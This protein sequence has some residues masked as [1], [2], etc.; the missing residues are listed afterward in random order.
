M[1]GSPSDPADV[2]IIGSG[3]AGAVLGAA[4]VRQGVRV[5]VLES[6]PRHAFALRARAQRDYLRGVDPWARQPATLDL[7][8]NAGALEYPLN[9]MRVRGVGGT[10]LHWQAETPRM[11]ASDFRMHSLYG[12]GADWPLPYEELEPYYV[13]AEHE[14]GVAGGEDPFA[15]PR[16]AP[17]PLPP[18]AYNYTDQLLVTAAEGM[19]LRFNPIPQ[20]RNSKPYG[21][22]S[23]CLACSTCYVCPIGAKASVDLTHVPEID[24]SPSGQVI[25]QATVL[26]LESDRNGRVTRAVYAGL[27]RLERAVEA[28]IFVIAGGGV[29]T[30]RLLLLSASSQWPDGLA[31][32]SGAVGKGLREHPICFTS[33]RVAGPSYSHRISFWTATCNQFWDTPD[34]ARRAAFSIF[35]NPMAGPTPADLARASGHWGDELVRDIERDFGHSLTI[36]CPIDML[37]YEQNAV[38]LDPELRDY[39]GS[40]VPRITLSLGRYEEEGIRDA[41]RVQAQILEAFGARDITANR[42]VGF[43]AHPAG[44][45]RMGS[46]PGRSVVDRNTRCHD[47]ANL[48]VV[49]TAV[50]P[51]SGLANPTLS[52]S[53]LALRLGDHLADASR[54]GGLP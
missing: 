16:S 19:G 37:S 48:Y 26:R 39:H 15:S 54:A 42:A 43:M 23:Q 40:P 50:F 47:V 35:F 28:T 27:D 11:H 25:E 4:L 41:R 52:I 13:R 32:R 36:E 5:V 9:A 45:C 14:L 46:D 18:F 1:I 21:G 17:Y 53:A 22:R 49:G 29:E 34:R 38:E 2:C 6:G 30:P 10:S 3:P 7:F 8:S 31:N 33:A 20:A 44:T 51:A 24:R 12:L